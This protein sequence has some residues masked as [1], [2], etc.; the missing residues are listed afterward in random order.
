MATLLQFASSM[1]ASEVLSDGSSW[2]IV[3]LE[4]TTDRTNLGL[5]ERPARVC[6]V[7]SQGLCVL[8]HMCACFQW[9]EKLRP[10]SFVLLVHFL[11]CFSPR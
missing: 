3:E 11:F 8:R 4:L 5:G 2:R 1:A 6:V 9:I 7:G 10:G